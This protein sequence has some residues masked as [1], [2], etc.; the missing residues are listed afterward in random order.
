MAA[1]EYNRLAAEGQMESSQ[2]AATE[3]SLQPLG[4]T[5][6]IYR[7]ESQRKPKW[8]KEQNCLEGFE[9]NKYETPNKTLLADMFP[10]KYRTGFS[11]NFIWLR[12]D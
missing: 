12:F 3:D 6:G 11:I 1:A 9:S 2:A 4:N 5:L 7:Y 10:N 8:Y